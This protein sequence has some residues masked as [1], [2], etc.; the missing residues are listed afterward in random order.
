VPEQ[1]VALFS[2]E[3]AA[4]RWFLTP[5]EAKCVLL[6]G[7]TPATMPA[8]SPFSPPPAS[9]GGGEGE[10]FI[11]GSLSGTRLHLSDQLRGIFAHTQRP[12]AVWT[13]QNQK[14]ASHITPLV[15]YNFCMLERSLRNPKMFANL[16]IISK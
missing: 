14:Q 7:A 6:G 12:C 3:A 5:W 10:Y 2:P 15:G 13:E 4:L 9:P 8:A 16:H 1:S 11:P